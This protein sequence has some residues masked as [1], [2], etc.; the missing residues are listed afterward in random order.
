MDNKANNSHSLQPEEGAD[1][2][3]LS[4]IWVEGSSCN[5]FR[6]VTMPIMLNHVTRDH[7]IKTRR[8]ADLLQEQAFSCYEIGGRKTSP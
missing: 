5:R 2:D 8:K 6:L 3:Q 7:Q 1:T 4:R